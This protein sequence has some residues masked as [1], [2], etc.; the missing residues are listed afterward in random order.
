[1][2]SHAA[3]VCANVAKAGMV[4]VYPCGLVINPKCP[5]LGCS[6]DRKVNDIQAANEGFNPFGLCEIKVVKEGE[7]DL[8]NVR[9]LEID[10]VSKQITL[11]RNHE[12]YFQVQCQLGLTG[13]EWNDFFCYMNDHKYFCQRIPFD[14][15]FFQDSK[16]KV[17]MFFF[18]YFQPHKCNKYEK[19]SKANSL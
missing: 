17:D 9:Y 13:L 5:W 7:T 14:K 1:M 15:N 6:P 19:T 18:H 3:T 16:D 4:N 11:K 10:S 2:E 12:H 8:K